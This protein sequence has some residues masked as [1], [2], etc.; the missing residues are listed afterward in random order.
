M[1]RLIRGLFDHARYHHHTRRMPGFV[2]RRIYRELI[3]LM[4]EEER[5]RKL[6]DLATEPRLCVVDEGRV[7]MLRPSDR[8]AMKLDEQ[9]ARAR[10]Q[11]Q[12]RSRDQSA[13]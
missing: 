11:E 4:E 6:L 1:F 13:E 9:M 12:Q 5:A 7:A 10:E 2:R 3:E 8:A